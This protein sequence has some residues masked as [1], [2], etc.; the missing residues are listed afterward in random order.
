MIIEGGSRSAGWWWSGHLQDKD[1]NEQVEL[2][3]VNGLDATTIPELFRELYAISR[4][5]PGVT[6]YF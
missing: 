2:V 1:K 3:E 4:A 5:A 6:N